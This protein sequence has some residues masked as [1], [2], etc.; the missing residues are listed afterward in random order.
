MTALKALVKALHVCHRD[1][2][3]ALLAIDMPKAHP[4]ALL[5][6]MEPRDKKPAKEVVSPTAPAAPRITP[7]VAP[8]L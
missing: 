1:A 5:A 3:R 7:V 6:L 4:M 8:K 2:A